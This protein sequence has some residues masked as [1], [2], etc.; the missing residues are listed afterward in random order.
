MGGCYDINHVEVN[1]RETRVRKRH[2]LP[3]SEEQCAARHGF[4]IA[5]C[6]SVLL[7]LRRSDRKERTDN[8][9][10]VIHR[11]GIM[12]MPEF[13]S[14]IYANC[15][16]KPDGSFVLHEKYLLYGSKDSGWQARFGQ[17]L[18]IHKEDIFHEGQMN[19]QAKK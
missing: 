16:F 1:D 14:G 4:G 5:K 12:E 15:I 13:G 7:R 3:E 11:D 8:G 9:E 6:Q 10:V 19:H 2:P 18:L 17:S